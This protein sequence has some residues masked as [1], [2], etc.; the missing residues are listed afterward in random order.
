MSFSYRRRDGSEGT[1]VDGKYIPWG[2]TGAEIL[3]SFQQSVRIFAGDI[4]ELPANP[5]EPEKCPLEWMCGA[6]H[7]S[8]HH[9]EITLYM[10]RHVECCPHT[11]LLTELQVTKSYHKHSITLTLLTALPTIISVHNNLFII[12]LTHDN[13]MILFSNTVMFGIYK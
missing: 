13:L 10:V 3:S 8:Q 1:E 6:L 2:V 7:G 12:S 5:S 9:S 4:C 11:G